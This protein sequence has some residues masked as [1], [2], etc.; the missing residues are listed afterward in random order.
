MPQESPRDLGLVDRRGH[1]GAVWKDN[2]SLGGQCLIA[3]GT[4]G[5]RGL[6]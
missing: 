4:L 6:G 1:R 2:L 3:A 5:N